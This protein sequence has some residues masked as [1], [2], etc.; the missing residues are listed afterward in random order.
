MRK[1]GNPKIPPQL[2]SSSPHFLEA[3]ITPDYLGMPYEDVELLTRDKVKLRCFLIRKPDG[4]HVSHYNIQ[5]HPVDYLMMISTNLGSCQG[6]RHCV[7]WEC[8]EP[9][10][11]LGICREVV[12]TRFQRIFTWISW[13]SAKSSFT[14][15]FEAIVDTDMGTLKGFLQKQASLSCRCPRKICWWILHAG[16]CLDA[17]AALDYVVND[18]VLSKLPVVSSRK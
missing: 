3:V 16:L 14:F 12:R 1:S 7:P 4:E 10:R 15:D 17:Q 11:Q 5:F 8:N 9:R 6:N 2:A 18:S 13:V